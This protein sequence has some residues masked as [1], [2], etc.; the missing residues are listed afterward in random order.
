MTESA[1]SLHLSET[2]EVAAP[3][4]VVYGLVTDVSRMGERS[5]EC[6]AARWTSGDPGTVGARFKG[7]NRRKEREWRTEC[8]VTVADFPR[9][10]AWA[11]LTDTGDRQTSVWTYEIEPADGGCRLTERYDLSHPPRRLRQLL[12]EA[13]PD[14]E[15][16]VMAKREHLL[17]KGMRATVE[18][19]RGEAERL[20]ATT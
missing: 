13:G 16:T 9:R 19:L 14:G 8:E 12:D 1:H 5:T 3:P 7:T 11:V 10:F 18:A 15:S 4:S 2:V 17:R 20:V 6:V